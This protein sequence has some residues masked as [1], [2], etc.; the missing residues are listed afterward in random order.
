LRRRAETVAERLFSSPDLGRFFD[1]ARYEKAWNEIGITNGEGRL[2]R[3]DR[4]VDCGDALWVLDYK[5]SYP[6]TG[7]IGE[8]R[9]QV[10][11]YCR[12]VSA[13]FP[14][15]KVRGALVFSDASLVEVDA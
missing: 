2:M 6:D 3:I 15:R 4:L 12:A 5:S 10:S 7:R 13:V 14:S 11:E 8:Y 1:P 9:D